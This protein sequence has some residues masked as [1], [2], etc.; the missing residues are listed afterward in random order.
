MLSQVVT[1]GQT[2]A[3]AVSMMLHGEKELGC[4]FM[5]LGA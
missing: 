1:T 3:Y 2:S 5:M 4:G